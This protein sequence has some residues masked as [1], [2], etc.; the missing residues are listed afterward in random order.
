MKKAI[1]CAA[2]LMFGTMAFAQVSIAPTAGTAAA[3]PGAGAG[4]NTGL[5][6]QNGDNNKVRVRQAGTEQSVLTFQDNGSGLGGNLAKV[7][8]TGSVQAASGF[9]NAAEVNQSGTA[10]QSS[11]RQEGDLNNAIT[12]QG[13]NDDSSSGNK[14]SIRQ[15]VAD[16]AESN[17]AATEQDGNN[18]QSS[19]VQTYDNSDAYTTQ[20][21]DSNKNMINQ[22][23]GPNG[24]DG[25]EAYAAQLGNRNESAIDQS[26]NGGRNNAQVRQF[27]DDNQSKQWQNTNAGSGTVGNSGYVQQGSASGLPVNVPSNTAYTLIFTDIQDN[28][29]PLDPGAT[30]INGPSF[31]AR[32]KQVQYGKM[33]EAAAWQTGGSSDGTN[34]AEQVQASGWNNDAAIIQTQ[35]GTGDNYAKQYQSGDNNL[36]NGWQFGNGQKSLQDQRG[37]RNTAL[38]SQAGSSNL[39]NQ[40]QRGTDNTAHSVQHGLANSALIVQRDGQSY[41]SLQNAGLGAFDLSAGGNQ[42]DVLQLGPNGDFSTDGIDCDFEDPMNLDMDYTVPGFD[43]GDVCPDC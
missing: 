17:F 32:A 29:T 42:V 8:Q 20:S 7:R 9:Q 31:G 30:V 12:N 27:G 38:G 19:T 28:I 14:A 5:S 34:Y 15:G 13:Q 33:N 26:G 41:T 37:H 11:T 43:L 40:H 25:H 23:A 22:N 35:I 18:N 21:G 36:A 3:L 6:I 24:T 1:L 4:A 39:L 2:A 10:N 16:Q